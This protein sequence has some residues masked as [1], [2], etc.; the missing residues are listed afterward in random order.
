MIISMWH[1]SL[2]SQRLFIQG[3]SQNPADT[4]QYPLTDFRWLERTED[5]THSTYF[6]LS[7]R[8]WWSHLRRYSVI[9]N[10]SAL[11]AVQMETASCKIMVVFN[12]KFVLKSSWLSKGTKGIEVNNL[13]MPTTWCKL[14]HDS[15]TSSALELESSVWTYYFKQPHTALKPNSILQF[16]FP[17]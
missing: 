6:I 17:N 11:A 7:T 15:I 10:H 4:N 3:R 13:C 14:G 5:P 8:K 9:T 12:E 1:Y 2:N 16:T